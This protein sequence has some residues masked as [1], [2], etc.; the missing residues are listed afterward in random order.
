MTALSLPTYARLPLCPYLQ[1][2]VM[3]QQRR[4]YEVL[5]H[6]QVCIKGRQGAGRHT[7]HVTH[8]SH[9]T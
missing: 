5:P 4:T 2:E 3:L 9:V 6:S 1:S 7:T 8:V